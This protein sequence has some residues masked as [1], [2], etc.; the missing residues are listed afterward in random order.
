MNSLAHVCLEVPI[1]RLKLIDR[2]PEVV[3]HSPGRLR[4]IRMRNVVD[5]NGAQQCSTEME[6]R[7]LSSD[8]R[9]R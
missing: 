5:E 2:V 1:G 4:C 3:L 6:G 9:L 7:S 8:G